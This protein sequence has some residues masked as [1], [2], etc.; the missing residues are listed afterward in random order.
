MV[1]R[2]NGRMTAEVR[3]AQR[4]VSFGAVALTLLFPVYQWFLDAPRSV[5][6][7]SALVTFG[8]LLI[9]GGYSALR[10]WREAKRNR[11]NGGPVPPELKYRLQTIWATVLGLAMMIYLVQQ[12]VTTRTSVYTA[13]LVVPVLFV[14]LL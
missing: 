10:W 2:R 14:V 1:A 8:A 12:L 7:M 5:I 4:A 6:T 3:F 13:V 11:P 9:V